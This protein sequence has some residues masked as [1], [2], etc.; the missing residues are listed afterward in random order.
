MEDLLDAFRCEVS[1]TDSGSEGPSELEEGAAD[2][3]TPWGDKGL[4][5]PKKSAWSFLGS[6]LKSNV[7]LILIRVSFFCLQSF[8]THVGNVQLDH[9]VFVSFCGG[10]GQDYIMESTCQNL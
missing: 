7:T 10:G 8:S 2:S 6:C 4:K 5:Y 3:R 1:D 9:I